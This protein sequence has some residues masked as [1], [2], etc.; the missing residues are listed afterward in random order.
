MKSYNFIDNKILLLIAKRCTLLQVFLHKIFLSDLYYYKTSL[1]LSQKNILS[2]FLH[3]RK[4]LGI[5]RWRNLVMLAVTPL[6]MLERTRLASCMHS[7]S[8]R[9]CLRSWFII[10]T[11]IKFRLS[12]R[13]CS[14]K[15][16]L[17][18]ISQYSQGNTCV[19]L[20]IMRNF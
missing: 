11:I 3:E 1:G 20:W 4:S 6:E 2:L 10:I 8:W 7:L 15:M 17:L 9:N 5:L 14:I 16:L 12:H 13:R 19:F 18:K